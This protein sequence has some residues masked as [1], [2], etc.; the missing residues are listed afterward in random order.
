MTIAGAA[1][2]PRVLSLRTVH[3]GWGRFLVARL[4]LGAGGEVDREVEDH[5]DAV[6]VLPYDPDR[7]EA[8][9]VRQLRT[10]A[11]V[12]AGVTTMLEAPAGRL[13]SLDPAACARREAFEECGVVL[14]DLDPVATAWA[15]PAVSTERIHLFL[16][17]Y[18]AQDR[19]GSGGGLAHEGE[20]IAV[21]I[22]PLDGLASMADAGEMPYMKTLLLIFA[23]RHRRPDLFG[24]RAGHVPVAASAPPQ[25]EGA[26]CV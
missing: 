23:L 12:A 1:D 26:P 21:E 14:G 4:R 10:P 8:L 24:V 9:L 5:G 2:A 18:N 20:D 7:R 16:A 19:T 15:M 22:L 13:E 25:T 11:L 3:Q 6:A 17:P